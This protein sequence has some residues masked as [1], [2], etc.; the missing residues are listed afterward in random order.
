MYNLEFA[1]VGHI[2]SIFIEGKALSKLCNLVGRYKKRNTNPHSIIRAGKSTKGADHQ[3]GG[4]DILHHSGRRRRRPRGKAYQLSL[5]FYNCD[6]YA[7]TTLAFR[8]SRSR[9]PSQIA[10]R[11]EC[12]GQQGQVCKTDHER[13]IR[14]GGGRVVVKYCCR[15]WTS[16]Q[17]GLVYMNHAN[18][19]GWRW[20]ILQASAR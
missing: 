6:C 14:G 8:S 12:R 3:L 5:Q 10:L 2:Q 16:V 18:Q 17:I 11:P 13:R 4:G 1:A 20:V 7:H 9:L 19:F 15:R